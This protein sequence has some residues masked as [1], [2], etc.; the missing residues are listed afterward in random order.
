MKSVSLA[1]ASGGS[2]DASS[3]PDGTI[4][5]FERGRKMSVSSGTCTWD[6]S[7]ASDCLLTSDYAYHVVTPNDFSLSYQSCCTT[8]THQ[9]TIDGVN[10]LSLHT[11]ID[12]LA[13]TIP[14]D[15]VFWY[16]RD[17]FI[18]IQSSTSGS[19]TSCIRSEDLGLSNNCILS[20]DYGYHVE[21][22]SPFSISISC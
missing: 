13:M 21:T 16:K 9:F 5:W 22:S 7:V 2:V 8:R 20:A 14:D 1:P 4:F 11:Q 10:S 6:D 15:T 3:A 18:L 19:V 17:N 12:L